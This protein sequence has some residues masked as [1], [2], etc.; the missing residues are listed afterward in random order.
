ML[1]ISRN[2]SSTFLFVVTSH[3]NIVT[4]SETWSYQIKRIL[5]DAPSV[6]CCRG[7]VPKIATTFSDHLMG[8][9]EM[10]F[11]SSNL[12]PSPSSIYCVSH[13][14]RFPIGPTFM[15]P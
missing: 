11:S 2:I 14:Y 9:D 10:H 15:I 6:R 12:P 13:V 4:A 8:Q 5:T 1:A 7:H 3:S